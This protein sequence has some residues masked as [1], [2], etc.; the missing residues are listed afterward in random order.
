MRLVAALLASLAMGALLAVPARADD[1][2]WSGLVLATNAKKPRTPEPPL[3]GLRDRLKKVFGYNQFVLLGQN[4][5]NM[6]DLDERWLMPSREFF[7]RVESK[8]HGKFGHL[9]D[10]QFFHEKQPLLETT[11]RLPPRCP[12]FI[13]GPQYGDGQL[14]IVLLMK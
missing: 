14:I 8:D 10:I 3:D 9:L 7:L 4:T 12:L 13:R 5:K 1:M 2:L 6:S 11:V